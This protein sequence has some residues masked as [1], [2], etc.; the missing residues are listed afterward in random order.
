MP[1]WPFAKQKPLNG[2]VG[3]YTGDPFKVVHHTTEGPSAQGAMDTFLAKKSDPHF[4]VDGT[5]I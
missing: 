4:T 3:P 1:I 5:T 2:A